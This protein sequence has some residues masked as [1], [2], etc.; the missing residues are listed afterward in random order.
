MLTQIS[1]PWPTWHRRVT[2][3]RP[4]SS[5]WSLWLFRSP[6]SL[7]L[8][9]GLSRLLSDAVS[10]HFDL[11][12]A[13]TECTELTVGL[14]LP[15]GPRNASVSGVHAP[16]VHNARAHRLLHVPLHISG[17]E[18]R[19]GN[20][21]LVAGTQH[22]QTGQMELE[23]LMLLASDTYCNLPLLWWRVG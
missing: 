1:T 6:S 17:R 16:S 15:S 10:D 9:S 4:I 12:V 19:F 13:V 3:A 7:D 2:C 21:S 23:L 18:R 22:Y 8:L 14:E 11:P 20:T 5:V